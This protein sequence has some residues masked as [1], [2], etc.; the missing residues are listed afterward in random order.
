MMLIDFDA[1][2]V[3]KCNPDVFDDKGYA[4]GWNSA[5]EILQNAPTV[6]AVAVVRCRECVMW[7]KYEN[8]AGCGYCRNKRFIFRYG[9]AVGGNEREFKP[10]TEPEFSCSDGKRKGGDEAALKE[11]GGT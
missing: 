3:G 7:K 4:N 2:G 5:I 9:G 10:I 1:L 6:D 11:R 8:T